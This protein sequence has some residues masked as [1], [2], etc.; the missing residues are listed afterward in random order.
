MRAVSFGCRRTG[1]GDDRVWKRLL[2]LQ[3]DSRFCGKSR[4]GCRSEMEVDHRVRRVREGVRDL[5]H[6]PAAGRLTDPSLGP[7][8]SLT[9]FSFSCRLLLR[10]QVRVCSRTI[11]LPDW[12][13][14]LLRLLRVVVSLCSLTPCTQ[15][16]PL[17]LHNTPITHMPS[18]AGCP[19]YL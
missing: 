13:L 6:F 2:L 4:L 16:L 14:L 17:F 19:S 3:T 12:F 18:V 7:T 15:S 9:P 5:G 10:P 11:L 8:P 1:S